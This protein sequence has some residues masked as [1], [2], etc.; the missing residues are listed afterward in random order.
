VKWKTIPIHNI[1]CCHVKVERFIARAQ[2]FSVGEDD[3]DSGRLVFGRSPKSAQ[4]RV[5]LRVQKNKKPPG[6]RA[7][8]QDEI[9]HVVCCLLPMGGVIS[10]LMPEFSANKWRGAFEADSDQNTS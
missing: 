1:L 3:S 6:E 5:M 9:K 7:A 10:P 8:V 2:V 4:R